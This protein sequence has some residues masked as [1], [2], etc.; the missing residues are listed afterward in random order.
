MPFNGSEGEQITLPEAQALTS[1]YQQNNPNQ[2]I[3]IF[4]GKDLI[5]DIL[6]QEGCM[7]VRMYYGEEDDGTQRLVLVGANSDKDDM[8]DGVI[9]DRGSSCPPQCDY[10]SPLK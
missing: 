6:D 9:A 4:M 10:T 5:H 3:A 1:N 7:G 2:T 8:T